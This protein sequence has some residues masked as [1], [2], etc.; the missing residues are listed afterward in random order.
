M[1]CVP[2]VSPQTSYIVHDAMPHPHARRHA[3]TFAPSR[4]TETPPA[5]F[6]P[7]RCNTTHSIGTRRRRSPLPV[8]FFA[9]TCATA[10]ALAH[11]QY[12]P[13][14][15]ATILHRRRCLR[16]LL[17][18]C[19]LPPRCPPSMPSPSAYV[20]LAVVAHH[21]RRR[22]ARPP[23]RLDLRHRIRAHPLDRCAC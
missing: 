15:A 9:H 14:A 7:A 13:A 17:V 2:V 6:H 22:R 8:V 21:T 19:G 12:G 18:H 5:L 23:A 4:A 1:Y 10:C 3:A 11:P 16:R 20:A